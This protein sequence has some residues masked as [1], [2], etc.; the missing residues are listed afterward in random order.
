MPLTPRREMRVLVGLFVQPLVAALTAF[1]LF[2]ALDRTASVAGAYQGRASNP[3][4]AAISVAFGAA[5]AAVFV[6]VFGALPAIAW[7]TRRRPITLPLTLVA[8]ALLGNAPAAAILLLTAVTGGAPPMR[9]GMLVRAL[10][11]GAAV[12][13]S[14]AAVFWSIAGHDRTVSD[15]T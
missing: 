4:D 8:G 14:C 13:T 1:I 2:P 7:L 15:D 9:A 12:G 6:V 11:F 5:F 3:L 10:L